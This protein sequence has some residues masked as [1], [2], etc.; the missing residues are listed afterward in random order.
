MNTTK[1]EM[2]G[3]IWSYRHRVSEIPKNIPK[4]RK[5]KKKK[6]VLKAVTTSSTHF[7]S[8]KENAIYNAIVE[9][10]QGGD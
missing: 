9:D 2:T 4:R 10:W 7:Q 3:Q 6:K 1:V 5:K 8:P